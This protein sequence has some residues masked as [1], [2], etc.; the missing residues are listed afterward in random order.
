MSWKVKEIKELKEQ[1]N[2]LEAEKLAK[3]E[4]GRKSSHAV[5]AVLKSMSVKYEDQERELEQVCRD[6][7]QT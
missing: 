1:V 3:E 5:Q 4:R 6:L 7:N 2:M